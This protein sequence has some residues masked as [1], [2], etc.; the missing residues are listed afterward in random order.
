MRRN[1]I[2][3]AC[4]IGAIVFTA[5]AS[6]AASVFNCFGLFWLATVVWAAATWKRAGIW[7]YENG[8]S[9]RTTTLIVLFFL[10]GWPIFFPWYFA[11]RLKIWLRVA[12]WHDEFD[13]ARM[14]SESGQS[15]G[16]VQPWRG[17]RI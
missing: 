15:G 6:L 7:R 16:L 4:W 2:A 3:A 1:L 5:L 10:F 13:P 14:A 9:Q 12:R 8:I 17:R 11:M